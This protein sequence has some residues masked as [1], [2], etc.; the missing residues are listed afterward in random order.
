[1]PSSIVILSGHV[2]AGKTTL[3]QLLVDRFEAIDLKTHDILTQLGR[4]VAQERRALHS[5]GEALD[6]RTQGAWVRQGLERAMRGLEDNAIIVVDS[7]R[8]PSQATAIRAGYG[9]VR[10]FTFT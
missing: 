10:L 5:F 2:G 8:I 7:I 9:L 4:D 3:A 1:M 6:K